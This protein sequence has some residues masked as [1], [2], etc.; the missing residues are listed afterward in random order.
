MAEREAVR[1]ADEPKTRWQRLKTRSLTLGA[2]VAALATAFVAI[3]GASAI[4]RDIADRPDDCKRSYLRYLSPHHLKAE[5]KYEVY[6]HAEGLSCFDAR[7]VIES[8]EH[9]PSMYVYPVRRETS[10]PYF[11]FSHKFLLA[12]GMVKGGQVTLNCD[13]SPHGLGGSEHTVQC[14]SGGE[15]ILNWTTRQT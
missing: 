11:H 2:A 7:S 6:I 12:P 13:Y 10:V 3:Y 9:D 8:F 5:R 15:V 1:D 4:V 14:A